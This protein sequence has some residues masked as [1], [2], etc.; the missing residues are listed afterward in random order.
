MKK[1]SM[2]CTIYLSCLFIVITTSASLCSSK[3][4]IIHIKVNPL[5]ANKGDTV[6]I[7]VKFNK[8]DISKNSQINAIYLKPRQGRFNLALKKVM[9]RPGI[10]MG[11]IALSNDSN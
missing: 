11:E 2:F 10:Y 9:N 1:G 4:G 8:N 6:K 7:E 3:N 5:R